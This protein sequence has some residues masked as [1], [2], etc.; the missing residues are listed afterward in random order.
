[1][2]QVSRHDRA[3]D[4]NWREAKIAQADSVKNLMSLVHY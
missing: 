3:D 4:E 1:M 2:E